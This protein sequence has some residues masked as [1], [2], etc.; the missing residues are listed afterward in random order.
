MSA[1]GS[2]NVPNDWS[3]EGKSDLDG[4]ADWYRAMFDACRKRDWVNGFALW[5]WTDRLYDK[6]EIEKRRDY[7]LYAKPAEDVVRENYAR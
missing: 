1:A 6:N 7:E 4:Q 3:V 2:K 5:S